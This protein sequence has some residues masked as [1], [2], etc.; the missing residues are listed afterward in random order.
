VA[1]IAASGLAGRWAYRRYLAPAQEPATVYGRLRGLAAFGGL[2]AAGPRTPYQFGQ[3]LTRRL[4]AY[5]ESV[6]V[7]VA[8]YV[9]SRYGARTLSL[10][11][12]ERLAD[13]WLGV[14][15]PLLR[16]SLLRRARIL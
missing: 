6:D 14:R 4:P 8:Y 2:N 15:Y 9:R 11:D 1:A 13:A 5:R 7:I 3:Q 12:R 16:L 10:G